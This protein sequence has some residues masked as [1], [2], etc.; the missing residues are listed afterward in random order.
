MP[1][2][3]EYLLVRVLKTDI[4]ERIDDKYKLY[5]LNQKNEYKI[6]TTKEENI[7]GVPQGGIISPLLMNWTLDGLQHHIKEFSHEMGKNLKIHS[8]DRYTM[9]KDRDIAEGIKPQKDSYYV[10]RS[11]IE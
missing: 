3:Y 2:D 10:N 7:R 5:K 9:L 8:E 6:I 4:F 11:R 1:T